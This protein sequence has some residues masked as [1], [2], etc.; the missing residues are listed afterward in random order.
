MS[1][2][3]ALAGGGARGAA[4]VGVLR[5][6]EENG[7][8]P[9]CISG[10]SAGSAV[11]GLYAMGRS[12]LELWNIVEELSKE[13]HNLMD[14]DI[15][16][17]L[18]IFGCLVS[19]RPVTLP[20]LFRGERLRA[21]LLRHTGGRKLSD[22]PLP[23]F[24]PAVDVNSGCTVVFHNTRT[25]LPCFRGAKWR[26][27]IPLAEAIRASCSVPMIFR[28][29]VLGEYCLVDGGVANVMPV[30]LLLAYGQ[31]N[32]IA[33]D[34]AEDY[35]LPENGNLFEIATHSFSIMSTRL[36]ECTSRGER[37]L[38]HPKLPEEAR[39]FSFEKMPECMQAGYEAALEWIP[40]IRA[41]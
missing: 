19:R 5:A 9:D 22:V 26:R 32:T 33:V 6:L 39:L 17:V 14:F 4:H 16:G 18:G 20:G 30:D 31:R 34:I 38:I 24:I 13:S 11:A 27:D 3:L 12:A 40:L 29:V 8:R 28:P 36:K 35:E 15:P 1:F 23:L 41:L 7:L 21:L 37:L 25:I 2:G 10:A